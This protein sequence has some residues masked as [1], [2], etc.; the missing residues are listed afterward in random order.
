MI[1]SAARPHP[2][3][4]VAV[5]PHLVAD[6]DTARRNSHLRSG[7]MHTHRFVLQF[8]LRHCIAFSLLCTA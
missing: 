5:Y 1:T 8:L 4:L 7:H 2:V 6:F 3:E